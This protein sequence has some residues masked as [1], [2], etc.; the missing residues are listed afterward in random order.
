M[1]RE[2]VEAKLEEERRQEEKRIIQ[3]QKKVKEE[4]LTI[5]EKI[6]LA[7]KKTFSKKKASLIL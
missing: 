7:M 2:K 4:T 3:H 1:H 5:N 6:G